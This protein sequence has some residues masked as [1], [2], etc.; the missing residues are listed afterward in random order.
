MTLARGLGM[1]PA[2]L[3]SSRRLRCSGLLLGL[4]LGGCT[5]GTET[6]NPSLTGQLSYTGVSSAP[7]D[8]GVRSGGAVATVKNAWFALDQVTVSSAGDCG[9]KDSNTFSVRA[10]GIGDH[11]A[12]VHNAT[13]F[14]ATAS[15]FC[16]VELPFA[17]VAADDMKA[18]AELRG[19]AV[20]VTGE[21]AD[22]TPFSIASAQAPLVRL[23]AAANGFE[24]SAEA[25]NALLAFDFAAWLSDLNWA[26]ADIDGGRID[27]STSSN[28]E[29][30]RK[31]EEQ[32]ASG[33]AL[34][35]DS[36]GDG[37]L[38]T[39]PELLADAP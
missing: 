32:L 5:G 34:Y 27:V 22:G 6:G 11:A 4:G 39:T 12:G 19:R 9:I 2:M 30:L 16:S 17:P 14:E 18:P 31:F 29:L 3:F 15:A 25:P 28:P 24:L 21:L 1:L 7:A 33:V 13:E 8:I 37:V 35:R 26:T 20:V 38:D 36:N 10:L 23:Q